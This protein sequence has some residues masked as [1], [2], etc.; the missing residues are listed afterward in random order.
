MPVVQCKIWS[1]VDDQASRVPQM[2]GSA[3]LNTRLKSCKLATA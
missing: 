3:E 2:S 1:I